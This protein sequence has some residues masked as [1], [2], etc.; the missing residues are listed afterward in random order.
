MGQVPPSSERGDEGACEW[1]W[2]LKTLTSRSSRLLV[3]AYWPLD[4]NREGCR[5]GGDCTALGE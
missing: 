4:W 3:S 1:V 5:E 2:G